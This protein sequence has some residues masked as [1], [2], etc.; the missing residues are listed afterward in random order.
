MLKTSPIP[1]TNFTCKK[2]GLLVK[3]ARQ[4]EE[5][6]HGGPHMWYASVPSVT[7]FGTTKVTV[8]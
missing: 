3:E 6:R 8:L 4:F 2:G 7:S 5:A 1:Q